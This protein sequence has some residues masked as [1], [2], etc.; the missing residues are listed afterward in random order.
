MAADAGDKIRLALGERDS[1]TGSSVQ[2]HDGCQRGDDSI[3]KHELSV[4]C[5]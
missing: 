3:N 1:Y 4:S 2:V 5:S